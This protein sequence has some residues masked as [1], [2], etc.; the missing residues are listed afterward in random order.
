MLSSKL[1]VKRGSVA[2]AVCV[3]GLGCGSDPSPAGVAAGGSAGSSSAGQGTSAGSAGAD[4]AGSDAG[5]QP[6]AG[7]VGVAGMAGADSANAGSGGSSGDLGSAGGAC[8]MMG[9]QADPTGAGDG[10]AAIPEPYTPAP[11]TLSHLK[12]APVGKVNGV[13]V[14]G[15][16]APLIYAA[17]TQ[18]PGLN[19][20]LKYEYWIYVPAQYKPGCA[21]A[22]MVFQDGIHYVGSDDAKFNA[23]MV[24]DNLI[25][26]G[27]MPV[28][29]ALF[30]NPGEPGAGHYDGNE[31][32]NRHVQYDTNNSNYANFL[33]NEFLEPIV[34]SKYAIVTDPD[35]WALGG[36]SSGGIAAFIAGWYHPEKFHKL[37]THDASFSNAGGALLTSVSNSAMKPLRVYL[38]SGPNDLP[39]WNQAN[40]D[41]ATRLAAKGYHYQFRTEN[42]GHYPPVA[43]VSDFANALRWMWRGYKL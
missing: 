3:L 29:I 6:A 32:Q 23:P 35:G 42:S 39:G 33:L 25:N 11:E 14:G 2:I 19:Q 38:M 9:M 36:H 10:K 4:T 15:K 17:K 1:H 5:G 7:S 18:Y 20:M 22:L 43:G 40:T 34:L 41:A 27:D 21:A 24:F 8:V 30:I 31:Y 26:S 28:T 37:L 16:F 12:S 13:D